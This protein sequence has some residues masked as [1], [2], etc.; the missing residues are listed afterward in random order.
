MQ[1][2]IGQKHRLRYGTVATAVLFVFFILLTP[3]QMNQPRM[4]DPWAYRF[5]IQN[6]AEGKWTVTDAEAA[7]GRMQARL[8][9]GHLTQYVQLE[10]NHWVLEKMPGYPLLVIPFY[11]LGVPQLANMMLALTAAA[12]LFGAFSAWRDEFAG[13]VGVVL[14]LFSPLALVAAH[15]AFM[16]TFASGAL[17]VIGGALALWYDARAG[18]G[19][20]IALLLVA[21]GF[22]AAWAVMV[23]VVSG[24]LFLL[25]AFYL[26]WVIYQHHG[27][28]NRKAWFHLSLF[29][30]GAAVV[31]GVFIAYNLA[32]FARPLD[33]GY[34][35]TPYPVLT[36]WGLVP[37]EKTGTSPWFV[38]QA[39][40]V[41]QVSLLQL[42]LWFIPLLLGWPFLGL[43]LAEF[44]V[45]FRH[46]AWTRPVTLAMLWLV[47]AF[48][49]Y[50]GY[51]GLMHELRTPYGRG[52][53]FFMP[54]RYV[55]PAAFAITLMAGSF[56]MRLSPRW[57]LPLLV[58]Y[59]VAAAGYAWY[60]L[61]SF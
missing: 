43:A 37:F 23:R 30:A 26:V 6:F 58:L 36:S 55:F 53:G 47:C 14:F 9:G 39:S 34:R 22:V 54:D 28:P 2:V 5:A 52:P 33:M 10:T 31:F 41:L 25:I 8:E 29:A 44:G 51:V 16:D 38:W 35:Y 7:E 45:R 12:V 60:V 11:K 32:V 46:R 57:R 3:F 27:W 40:G 20:G 56:L 24:L 17:L 19:R 59:V 61:T 42:R 18:K 4:P 50:W 13:F 48:V 1:D 15:Y 21:A 49:P